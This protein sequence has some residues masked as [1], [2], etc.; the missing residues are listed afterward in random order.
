M[1]EE[2]EKINEMEL[3]KKLSY[4][5]RSANDKFDYRTDTF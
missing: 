2:S 1:A 3:M 4:R 5:N